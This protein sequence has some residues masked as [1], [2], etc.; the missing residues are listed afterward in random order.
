MVE[1]PEDF[2][3]IEA[4]FNEVIEAPAEL[5]EELLA[6]RCGGNPA[7]T[8]QVR[9]LLDACMAE[10][11]RSSSFQREPDGSREERLKRK[12][13][14]PY[15]IDRLLGRGGMGSVYLAH[16]A[17]GHFEQ[18]VAIKLIDVPLA[19]EL[20]RERF[21]QERQI[22]A[23]L[24]HPYIARLLDGGISGENDL[25]LVMEYVDG[26]PIHRFC[27][28]RKLSQIK[29]IELFL[30][31]C[32]AVQFAHQ[33]FVVHRDLKPDNILVAADGMPRLLDFGTAKLLSPSV[34]KQDSQLTREGYSSFTP[35]Y[36]SPEQVLGN[37]ITTASDTYS[38]GVLL[39]LLL[40]GTLPYELK[41]LTMGQMM[42]TVCEDAP[43]KPSSIAGS[44]KPLDGD[45][46]AILLKALRKEPQERYL[47]AE[48]M[49]D[50]LRAYLDGQPVAARRGTAR[51]RAAKFISR[52]RW[53]LGA[54]AL[55]LITL[56]A[57]IAGVAWQASVANRERRKAE[58]RSADLRQLSNSLLNELDTAIQQIPG[59][60]DAQKLLVTSVLKHL[61]RMAADAHGDRQTQLDL[62]D[63]YTRLAN[64]QGN[65]SQQNL[66]DLAGA[67][68]SVN[69]AIAM[70]EPFASRNSKDREAIHTLANAQITRGWILIGTGSMQQAIDST[71]AAINNFDRIG[72]VA[73]MS[74]DEIFDMANSY[75]LLGNELG[76]NFPESLN[77]LPGA[78]AAYRSALDLFNQGKRNYP[79]LTYNYWTGG[80]YAFQ[81]AI[82]DI[83]TEIDP[84]KS[85]ID[86]KTD[87]QDVDALPKAQRESVP[88]QQIRNMLL[89]NEA[90]VLVQLGE[91]TEANALSEEIVQSY[92]SF[93]AKDPKDL[94]ALSNV[95]TGL[96]QAAFNYQTEG[97]PNL[98]PSADARRQSL[99]HAE[100][101]LTEELVVL[102][103]LMKQ[104][105]SQEQWLNYLGDTEINLGSIRY[106]LHH[107]DDSTQLVKEGLATYRDLVKS[108]QAPSEILDAAAQDFLYAEPAS[109]KD[110][111]LAVSCAERAVTLSHRKMPSRLLT[112]AQAYRATD[113]TAKSR[114]T[115]IEALALLPAWLPGTPKPRLRKLLEI[116][117]QTGF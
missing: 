94:R 7:L 110:P 106:I 50:D 28:E 108:N 43:R 30:R 17:D 45:L 75:G 97:D 112:L 102:G 6:A 70:S 98:A 38:L 23:G 83:E 16:R 76:L 21:R 19:T 64:I 39:Y 53:P 15:E 65:P 85:L 92:K 8:G 54:V 74:P 111:Q 36:A 84:A 96:V 26:V 78:L 101:T 88:I 63:G 73:K 22:L 95:H 18:K 57:G 81:L 25:Y 35:Q 107:G 10:E 44:G 29:R 89:Q 13:V 56:L 34:D 42:K 11:R 105:G 77:D 91:Y 51:Y 115:A 100:Q 31:A 52:H 117:A 62:A 46:E 87:L 109:L 4:I 61:D 71:R 58:A 114:A 9:L 14:G 40:T 79:D 24:Q 32:E 80:R 12:R 41:D 69:K 67:L 72:A 49:A 1:T 99:T 116:Q 3:Q 2:P 103:K 55:L 48:R 20:F 47:T 93:S 27:E 104:T 37:P 90:L 86:T 82:I 5:R 59:S 113:Q 68:I 60:T 33:N 66:G